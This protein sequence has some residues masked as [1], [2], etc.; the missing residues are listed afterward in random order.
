MAHLKALPGDLHIVCEAT[1]GYEH[2]L[3]KALFENNVA[4][5]LV[6]PRKIRDFARARGILAKT[7][8]IDALVLASYGRLLTPPR[9]LPKLA[10]EQRLT[11]LVTRRQ[12]LMGLIGQE[13]NRQE[14]HH[15]PFVV[16]QAK[17]L[18]KSLKRHVQLIEAEL[19]TLQESSTSIALRVER[20]SSIQGIAQRTSWILLAALPE[21]GTLD[22]GQAAALAGLAPYNHDSGPLRGKRHIAHGRPL[23][24]SA[25]YMAALGAS[26]HNPIL[27][28]A[29]KHLRQAGK[30]PKVA[31]TALMRR[32]VELANQIL[33]NPKLKLVT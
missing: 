32:L 13:Q 12:E 8:R 23:A 30:P 29:Y 4:V 33:K 5:S 6:N 14:H 25:L 20:L 9:T 3:L 27:S 11:Q 7:D 28:P 15:D 17:S 26:R 18:I 31:L 10:E 2:D 16:K 19:A 22:R 24:R 21:L 1:G